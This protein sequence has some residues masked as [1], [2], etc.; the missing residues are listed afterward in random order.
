ML[1]DLYLGLAG[2]DR[3]GRSGISVVK[4]GSFHSGSAENAG[5]AIKR[6]TDRF[7]F[8]AV[9]GAKVKKESCSQSSLAWRFSM[10]GCCWK[11]NVIKLAGMD[12]FNDRMLLGTERCQVGR[13][14]C[15]Q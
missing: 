6:R 3:T 1:V 15:F 5:R 8:Q 2:T 14:G 9:S 11:P 13:H 10:I 7:W 4:K 12:A